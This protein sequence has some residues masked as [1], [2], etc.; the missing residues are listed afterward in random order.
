M[1][2]LLVISLLFIFIS[3]CSE[4]GR[5]VKKGSNEEKYEMAVKMYK[6]KDYTRALPLFEDLLAVYRGK[7]ESEE[8]YFYYS[9]C[10]YGLGMYDLAAYHFKNF[11]ENYINSEHMEECG[12]RHTDCL[13]LNALPYY[14]DQSNTKEAIV[15][16]QLFL[17]IYPNST[18]KEE[19][20]KHI[21]DLRG[22]LKKKAFENAMLFYKIE[23]YQAATVSF[24]NTLRDF[25][26]MENKD[27][28]EFLIVKCT[29]FYAKYS[30]E[31]KKKER[32]QNVF[33]E[34]K[35]YVKNN[36]TSSQWYKDATAFNEKA[37]E[38]L[39][40]HQKLNNIK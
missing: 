39:T 18:Y 32:Y 4:Y 25:P 21:E 9:Y 16:I 23:D 17:N 40:K 29:Y 5:I 31:E 11:T 22:T 26:D 35:E 2:R 19:C 13:Y 36:G 3:S 12:Y 34:Y 1:R 15:E 8:I 20:N 24:K 33:E 14:L 28:I 30:I 38:E 6:K 10:Y 37:Q 7:E 27:Q